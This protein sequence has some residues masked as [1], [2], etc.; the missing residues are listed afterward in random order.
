MN[1]PVPPAA[2]PAQTPSVRTTKP[3]RSPQQILHQLDCLPSL[4]AVANAVLDQILGED[5]ENKSLARIIETDPSLTIKIL[6]HA[7]TAIYARHGSISQV[8]LALNRLG[9]KVIQALLLSVLI[10][11]SLLTGDKAA[12]AEQTMLWRHSLA[13]GVLASLIAA[14]S[15]PALAGEA[16]GAGVMH[17]IGRIFLRLFARDEYT[18]VNERVQEMRESVIDAEQETFKTDHTVIGRLIA[19]KWKLPPALSDAVWLHH[20]SAQSMS[21]LRTDGNHIDLVAIVALA[22]LLAHAILIDEPRVIAQEQSRQAGLMAMLGL[23]SADLEEIQKA[24]APAFAE[25]AAAFN[26]ETDQVALFLSSLQKANQHLMH[27]SLEL[28]QANTRLED[29]NRFANL[30]SRMGLRMSKSRSAEE[31][32]DSIASCMQ[33][34]VGVRGGFVYWIVPTERLAQGLI[35]NG[36]GSQRA[37]SYPLNG[38]GLPDLD[39]GMA[40]PA[41]LHAIVESHPERHRGAHAMDRALRLKQFFFSHGYCIFPLVGADFVGE[42]CVL[43]SQERPPK[44][45]PQEYMGYAQVSC[46]ASATLDRVRLFNDLQLRADELAHAL[47]KNQQIN[48]QLLQTERLAAVG[49]LAAGAAHEINNPLAIISAR[50]Q[51][52]EA[53]ETDERKRKDLH[54]ISEQI[55]RISAILQSLMGFARPNAPQVTRVDLNALLLKI[56]GLVESVFSTHQIPIVTKLDPDLPAILADANQLEQVFLNLV[57]NAQHAMEKDGGAL[58]I[59]TAHLAGSRRIAVTVADT[60]AGIAPENLSRIFDPFFTTKSEGKGTGLGLSTAYG[61]VTNHYGEI[62]VESEVGQGTRMQVILPVTTPVPLV[63]PISIPVQPVQ[64]DEPGPPRSGEVR[65]LVV[66][67]EQHIRDILAE[68]LRDAGYIV[69]M[70]VNGDEAV[71]KLRDAAWDALIL[72]IRMPTRSGLELL[73]D[74]HRTGAHPPI[75]VLTGLASSDEMAEALRLGAARCVR[76]PFQV[77]SLLENIADIVNRN[78][79]KG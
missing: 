63:T 76:K 40:L 28:E 29:A 22:N 69:D 72:D 73:Q 21:S 38:D 9:R 35:W 43:R 6:G 5:F 2:T 64:E 60:G 47:W 20:H 11:D 27:M 74:L 65:I 23:D 62:K 34:A 37:V 71:C 46:V 15:H 25:R 59:S 41:S 61:I 3:E 77:R 33:D 51:L 7:N 75:L 10:K 1:R 57:I 49:Q 14:K 58:T 32:F 44:M 4:P 12:E 66:D 17:D 26:L 52:L 39:R 8:E 42:M 19:Q 68:T 55:E 50:S 53:R 31:V 16:F 56:I 45:T 18:L 67:D 36:A 78:P 79:R 30:G 24:F 70:A 13:T 54:Q 48:L